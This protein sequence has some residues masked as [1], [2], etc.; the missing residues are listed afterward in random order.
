M[1]ATGAAMEEVIKE[2]GTEAIGAAMAAA[3]AA[4]DI[5]TEVITVEAITAAP[6]TITFLMTALIIITAPR[7]GSP[8][9][10]AA[11]AGTATADIITDTGR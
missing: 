11:T 2:A 5:T 7:M 9:V 10:L 6:T 3:T 4:E 1:V 8:S